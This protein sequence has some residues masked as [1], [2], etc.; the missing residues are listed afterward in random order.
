[1]NGLL[2]SFINHHAVR[3]GGVAPKG[4]IIASADV[5]NTGQTAPMGRGSGLELDLRET[6]GLVPLT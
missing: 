6:Q 1:M 5:L 3:E 2:S 4:V